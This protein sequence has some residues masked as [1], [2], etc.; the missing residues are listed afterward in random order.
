MWNILVFHFKHPFSP[1]LHSNIVL[2]FEYERR[3]CAKTRRRNAERIISI[4]YEAREFNA[5]YTN[6]GK[7]RET[8]GEK[9]QNLTAS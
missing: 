7:V 6:G 3:L 2:Y 9:Y 5:P 8:S 4:I 1:K